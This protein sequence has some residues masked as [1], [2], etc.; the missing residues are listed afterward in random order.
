MKHPRIEMTFFCMVKTTY[1]I[2]NENSFPRGTNSWKTR[3]LCTRFA[4]KEN[5][6]IILLPIQNQTSFFYSNSN[7]NKKRKPRSIWGLRYHLT[8][9][10]Y[11]KRIPTP[12]W[13]ETY[14]YY[15]TVS[16]LFGSKNNLYSQTNWDRLK[17]LR[18]QYIKDIKGKYLKNKWFGLTNHLDKE[19]PLPFGS[20]N[21]VVVVEPSKQ[22]RNP[23]T[24]FSY[25]LLIPLPTF[26]PWVGSLPCAEKISTK[27]PPC[28]TIPPS[29]I[30]LSRLS[31]FIRKSNNV[32][33]HVR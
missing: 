21:L 16:V 13:Y 14:F 32:H 20:C 22:Y 29:I 12:L 23:L 28:N 6:W 24:S 17:T 19:S 10:Q 25:S 2:S 18:Y 1:P 11:S 15:F 31:T 27:G 9:I 30:R 33:V 7:V 4:E 5:C 8:E 26:Q 3:Y